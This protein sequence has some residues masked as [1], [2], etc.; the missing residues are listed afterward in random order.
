M[1]QM[2]LLIKLKLITKQTHSHRKQIFGYQRRN[3]GTEIIRNLGLEN[4]I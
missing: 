4:Y 2:N 3:E 1:T